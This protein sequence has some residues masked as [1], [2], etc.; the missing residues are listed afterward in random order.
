MK[1]SIYIKSRFKGNPRGPGRAVA[2]IEYIDKSGMCHTRQQEVQIEHDTRNALY[3]EISIVAM[4]LL[5]KPCNITIYV[6]C[7]YISNA[8]RLGWVENWQ[9]E[10]W[11]R[12]NGNPPANVDKWKQFYML[13]QIHSVVFAKYESP[14]DKELE[15]ILAVEERVTA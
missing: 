2:I 11:K 13:T 4:R 12:A 6:D 5:L 7:D 3:L 9:R 10:G 1:V 8:H 15:K 14:Y